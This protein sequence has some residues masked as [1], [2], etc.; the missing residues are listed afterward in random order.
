MTA[1][2]LLELAARVLAKLI[3]EHRTRLNELH[4]EAVVVAPEAASP[5]AALLPAVAAAW[6]TGPSASG[7]EKGIPSSIRSPPASA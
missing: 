4:H 3:G 5:A 2:P 7:S 6:M 1:E